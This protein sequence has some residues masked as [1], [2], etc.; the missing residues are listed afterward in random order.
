LS[1][2]WFFDEFKIL[3]H[4]KYRHLSADRNRASNIFLSTHDLFSLLLEKNLPLELVKV[5]EPNGNI[6]STDQYN[7]E[8]A[9]SII[10]PLKLLRL[11]YQSEC[12]IV[13]NSID[14]FHPKIEAFRQRLENKYNCMIEVNCYLTPPDNQTF[15]WHSDGHQVLVLHQDGEKFWFV[16]EDQNQYEQCSRFTL[17]PGDILEIAEGYM[18]TAKASSKRSLH[19]TFSLY[20]PN[21]K[22]TTTARLMRQ[23]NLKRYQEFFETQAKITEKK[24]CRNGP[25]WKLINQDGITH[26]QYRQN[27]LSTTIDSKVLSYLNGPNIFEIGQ[28]KDAFPELDL[29][30]IKYLVF[31]LIEKELINLID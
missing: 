29:D 8:L 15:G 20:G 27:L 22:A 16:S 28:I 5:I 17:R 7:T 12:S 24:F 3:S 10:N 2:E 1:T 9:S 13:I 18:H 25:S 26:I 21:L 23:E 30:S 6:L 31:E 4:E 11:H 14:L 19:L